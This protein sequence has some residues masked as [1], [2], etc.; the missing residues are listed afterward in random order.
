M[1]THIRRRT[2]LRGLGTSMAVPLLEGMLPRTSL[3][4]NSREQI[5]PV[6][7][8]FLFVPNGKHM[9]HWTPEFEGPLTTLP[10]ILQPLKDLK[11]ELFLPSGLALTT[12]GA[13][14][15]G[16]HSC[17]VGQFLTG[18]LPRR[19]L[20]NELRNGI[21]VDQMAAGKIG[22]H[23]RFPS[24]ELGCVPSKYSGDCDSG[25]SCVYTTH[26]S[27]RTE[28]A[29]LPK[30]INPRTVFGQEKHSGFRGC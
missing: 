12:A 6:R 28:T 1:D 24:L 20:G 11:S 29:P 26:I 5:S 23:T 15:C 21:S 7:M 18:T 17:T 19:T 4:T 22:R 27:W 30:A 13:A 9:P 14:G 8:A 25:Y 2:V 10:P 3:A 16:G